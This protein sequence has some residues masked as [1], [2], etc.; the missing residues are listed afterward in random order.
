M[1]LDAG[2]ENDVAQ[3]DHAVLPQRRAMN[4][5]CAADA[6]DHDVGEHRLRQVPGHGRRAVARTDGVREDVRRVL[7][8]DVRSF[9]RRAGGVDD[10]QRDAGA[11][12][13]RRRARGRARW[14]QGC[15]R[16]RIGHGDECGGRCARGLVWARL[17]VRDRAA[18]HDESD[19]DEHDRGQARDPRQREP[20]V[21]RLRQRREPRDPCRTTPAVFGVEARA[22]AVEAFLSSA[23]ARCLRG[24]PVRERSTRSIGPPRSAAGSW[25]GTA[26]RVRAPRRTRAF[27]ARRVR[28]RRPRTRP[29]RM[30]S[31]RRPNAR[32]RC[33]ATR[34]AGG[35]GSR[36]AARSRAKAAPTR[37][38][39][40]GHHPGRHPGHG[41][42]R[43][44][45]RGAGR[46]ATCPGRR[47]PRA[48]DRGPNGARGL[49]PMRRL[50]GPSST[51]SRIGCVRPCPQKWCTRRHRWCT[52]RF[53]QAQHSES[54]PRTRAPD[55]PRGTTQRP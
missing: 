9:E 20:R 30:R 24:R 27:G 40:P 10:A 11:T 55:G 5:S 16:S 15:G 49:R 25:S 43:G 29:R 34:A 33:V 12:R 8:A 28:P 48:S 38:P 18:C 31:R 39:G 1:H 45:G 26:R 46:R 21:L 6:F 19:G 37:R 32:G 4:G 54:D 14:V 23:S 52:C 17:V 53:P 22:H 35:R 51:S 36:C 7:D 3:R 41:P 13:S 42:G 50:A 44:S 2:L 47:H